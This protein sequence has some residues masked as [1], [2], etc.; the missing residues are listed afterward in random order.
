M[1]GE[2]PAGLLGGG[3][4]KELTPAA[5]MLAA[6]FMG[7]ASAALAKFRPALVEYLLGWDGSANKDEANKEFRALLLNPPAD[8]APLLDETP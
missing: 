4:G 1:G 8:T 7:F 6:A 3:S 2:S 5:A